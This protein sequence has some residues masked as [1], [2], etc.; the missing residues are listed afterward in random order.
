MSDL[1]NILRKTRLER[2]ISLDDLQEVTKIRKRYLEAIEEGNYKVLPGSFYVRAFI[3]S[4]AEAVGLDPTEVLNMYQT[5]NPSLIVDKPVVETIRTNRTSVRNTEK[6]SRWASSVMFICFILLIFGIVYY[7]TYKNYK[8]T[9]ADQKPSQTQSSRITNSTNPSS[10]VKSNASGDGKVAPLPTPTPTPVPT[11]TPAAVQVKFSN[12]EKGVDN[13]TIT[14][15]ANL[16]IKM[17]ITGACWIRIDSLAADG[18]KENMLR[19]KLY[20]AGDT[21]AFDLVSSAYLNVGA[22][23]ALEL[24]VNGTVIPVGDTPNPKRIQL[25][26]QKN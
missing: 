12:S 17:K 14:G 24:N 7:Y 23:S 3:K 22:A 4:Y 10:S 13:Y 5:T 21:D 2:K 19:Q 1:G 16:N 26:L 15:T 11:Q 9:P 20:N 25:N 18:A 8:G 6:L